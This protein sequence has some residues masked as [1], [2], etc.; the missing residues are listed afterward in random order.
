MSTTAYACPPAGLCE[1]VPPI[2]AGVITARTLVI[3]GGR[4]DLLPRA[5]TEAMMAALPNAQL[6]VYEEAGHLVLWE[7]PDRLAKDVAAFLAV[8]L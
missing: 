6:I 4:D 8:H 1:A 5:D 3:R 7:R 2:E